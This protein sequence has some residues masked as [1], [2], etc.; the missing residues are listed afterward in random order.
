MPAG[1]GLSSDSSDLRNHQDIFKGASPSDTKHVICADWPEY[2]GSS[3][4]NGTIR[5]GTKKNK[6]K[7][8]ILTVKKRDEKRLWWFVFV[9]NSLEEIN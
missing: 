3:N 2:I 6:N 9:N 7:F 5:G 4:A 8:L 1:N